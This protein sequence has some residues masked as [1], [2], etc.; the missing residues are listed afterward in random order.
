MVYRPTIGLEIHAQLK[1]QTKL[2]CRSINNPF[3][4]E[5]NLHV[6]PICLGHPG[7]L[8]V[9]NEEA[10][11][12]TAVAGEALNCKITSR[13]FF[14]R[15]NYFYPDIPKGYQI[16]QYQSPLCENGYLDIK[17]ETGIKKIRIT[18]IHL[19]EDTGKLLHSED[20]QYSLVDFN[21]AGVPLME[22]VTEPDLTSGVEVQAFAE[23]LRLTLRYLG[24]SDA[25]ME[26]GQMRVEVNISISKDENLGTKVEIKNLNSIRAA[27]QS[28]DFEIARQAKLLEAEESVVQETRGWNENKRETFSQ[29]VKEG[30]ADYR[31]FPEPDLPPLN[32]GEDFIKK[33]KA[34]IGELPRQR[35]DRFAK[36]YRLGGEAIEV[37]VQ[38]KKLGDF[39]EQVCSEMIAWDKIEHAHRPEEEH[40][41][42]LFKI[43]SNFLIN[44]LQALLGSEETTYSDLKITPHHLGEFVVRVFHK[45]ISSSNATTLL[46]TMFETGQE[47]SQIIEE[48]D[49]GQ[50][51][52]LAEIE[53]AVVAVIAENEVAVRDFK[54]GKEASLQFLVGQVMAKTKGKADPGLARDIIKKSLK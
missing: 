31:Y 39:F 24:V 37:L 44:D 15:K 16:S 5:P 13:T 45:E 32:L 4:K 33:V 48:Q 1:T 7:T 43:A 9:L 52:D 42:E 28:V 50:V 35:R 20:G 6:C 12:K 53:K 22:L 2:F 25:D 14:E 21:R 38:N 41:P 30:S 46:G 17:T 47:P 34:R 19:E 10:L 11:I 40:Y 27:A 3:E 49:L 8:P 29:R 54:A 23:E 36:E 51:S 18:R 26:K